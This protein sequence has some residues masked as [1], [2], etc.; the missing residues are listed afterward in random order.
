MGFHM[1]FS[2]ASTICSIFK[3]IVTDYCEGV[4]HNL[5]LFFPQE[6]ITGTRPELIMVWALLLVLWDPL[7]KPWRI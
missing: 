7:M 4:S 6:K 3:I 2:K 1:V 5:S